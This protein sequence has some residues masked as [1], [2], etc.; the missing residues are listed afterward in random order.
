MIWMRTCGYICRRSEVEAWKSARVMESCW[1]FWK[2][3]A[4]TNGGLTIRNKVGILHDSDSP[5]AEV[6]TDA[7][8][9]ILPVCHQPATPS[10]C[11]EVADAEVQRDTATY[12]THPPHPHIASIFHPPPA[13]LLPPATTSLVYLLATAISRLCPSFPHRHATPAFWPTTRFLH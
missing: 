5:G 9:R 4:R 6:C 10:A 8:L 1:S 7:A 12:S 2:C 3:A 13:L 11:E